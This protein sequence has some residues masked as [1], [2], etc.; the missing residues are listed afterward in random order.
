MIQTGAEEKSST[1]LPQWLFAEA[2]QI[3]CKDCQEF[4]NSVH[5]TGIG[6]EASVIYVARLNLYEE[7]I[8]PT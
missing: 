3:Y 8:Y 6:R 5:S 4:S 7:N 2:Y 1:Q